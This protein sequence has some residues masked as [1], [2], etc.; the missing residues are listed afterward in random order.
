MP[1]RSTSNRLFLYLVGGAAVF[2]ILFGVRSLASVLNPILL[3]IVITITVLPVPGWL[4]KRGV[5]GWLSFVLTILLVV[6]ILGLVMLTVFFSVS[7]LSLQFPGN[8]GTGLDVVAEQV[9][10]LLD[11]PA[12][13]LDP[14]N[15]I[16]LTLSSPLVQSVL[17]IAANILVQFGL[18]LL[19]FFFM[20]SAAVSLPDAAR[21]G[22]EPNS[23]TMGRFQGL[24]KD[25][26]QYM[27]ILTGINFLVGMGNTVLLLIL[28]V[29][30][31]LLW[32]VLA[33][34]MGYIPSVGFLIALVPPLVLG[35][36]E[37]GMTT[38]AII[39]VG[40]I[41]I[42]GGIQNFIQPRIMGDGVRLSPVVVYVSL[43]VWAFLLG[44]IGAILAVPLTLLVVTFMENF[45]ATRTAAALMRYTGREVE[46][47]KPVTQEALR[48]LK[49]G[50]ES[51]RGM[52]RLDVD[53]EGPG[54]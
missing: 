41:V 2:V 10:E 1:E 52:L 8:L 40:Y 21:L 14:G 17:G 20:L 37:H 48:Q 33:W 45:D 18:T 23:P 32:G 51:L 53:V 34:F 26:R 25:V 13:V 46:A 35:Y 7:R 11:D 29:D 5:P 15:S 9:D 3:A 43:F 50:W 27:T 39:L 31:A 30:Y 12:F 4:S 38:A 54:E 6:G 24:T 28:G 16:N 19:I 44:G 22:I 42:N 49:D 36:L 47:Q